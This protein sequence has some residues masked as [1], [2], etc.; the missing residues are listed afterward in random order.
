M[1]GIEVNNTEDKKSVHFP[2]VAI[3]ASAGG[4]EAFSDLLK[5]LP[6]DTGMSYIYIQHLDPNHESRL[7]EIV[8]RLTDMP[9]EEAKE[10][11]LIKPDHVY[12]IP[13]NREMQLLEG[14]LTLSA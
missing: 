4:L 2:I 14:S 7:T 13:P 10:K 3:G 8:S 9:V 5:S 11:M 1:K 6:P 12:I